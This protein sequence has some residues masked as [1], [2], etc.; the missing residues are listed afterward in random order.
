M[1]LAEV[2]CTYPRFH[3]V[4]THDDA[5]HAEL[6]LISRAT[7][8]IYDAAAESPDFDR[9]FGKHHFNATVGLR[10]TVARASDRAIV[11]RYR[12]DEVGVEKY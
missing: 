11:A 7:N 9:E 3:F 2:W 6:W 10:G 5:E 4:E 1:Y 8:A 12:S